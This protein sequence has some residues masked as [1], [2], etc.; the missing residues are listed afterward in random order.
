MTKPIN[1]KG[2]S[3]KL[4]ESRGYIVADVESRIPTTFITKD[5]WG[6]LD[7]IAVG[8]GETVGVQVTTYSNVSAR[9]KKITDSPALPFLREANWRII[10]EGW[11]KTKEK[12][13]HL[14][15]EVD[16]S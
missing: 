10:V 7:T 3:I 12:G 11:E 14:R 1:A 9:V 15:R 13:L 16:L 4:W 8:N 5:A 6:V 2:A